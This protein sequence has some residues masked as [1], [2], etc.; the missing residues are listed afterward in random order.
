[1]P[2]AERPAPQSKPLPNNI[3]E[4][5][6]IVRRF[7]AEYRHPNA[8]N[9]QAWS[10]DDV[11]RIVCALGCLDHHWEMVSVGAGERRYRCRKCAALR[12]DDRAVND[13]H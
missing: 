6:R 5:R 11:N 3:E 9:G 10:E 1:M 7:L 12:V 4:R 2:P 13:E 8:I